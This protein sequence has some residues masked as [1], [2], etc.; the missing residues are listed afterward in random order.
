MLRSWLPVLSALLLACA[1][2][3]AAQT[4]A[5]LRGVVTVDGVPAPGAVVTISSPALQGTRAR[6]AGENGAYDFAALPPGLYKVRVEMR[7]ATAIEQ[8]AMLRL[9]EATRLDVELGA[10]TISEAVI[11]TAH[12]EPALDT[13]AVATNLTLHDVELLP[14]QRNQNAS[15]QLAP[16]VSAS[17]F[18]Q[19]QLQ[20][21][22]GPSYDNL[23]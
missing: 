4:T 19:G 17:A 8:N 15:S 18:G 7:G 21:S 16:G 3:L 23:V 11:V 1:V 6:L 5:S 9:A 14:V 20:I 2:P 22:G 10:R 12:E 13:P